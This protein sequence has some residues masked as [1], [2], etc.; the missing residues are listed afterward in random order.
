[1]DS[2]QIGD[3]VAE[4]G[5]HPVLETGAR[6]GYAV[7]GLLHMLI[8]VIA[9]R[10]AWQHSG[11]DADQSGALQAVG[12]NPLGMLLLWVIL[13][14]YVLL[15]LWQ[16]TESVRPSGG[17][18]GLV[19]RGKGLAKTA[20]YA[21]LALT[22][23]RFATGDSSSSSQQTA[24]FTATLMQA[25]FGRA[26]VAVVGLVVL[27]VGGYHVHKGVQKRFLRDLEEHPGR[28]AVHAGQFGYS[29]KGVA[30]A[31]VGVLF[32][33]AALRHQ[34]SQSTGLDGALRTLLGQPFGPYLL[35]VV[36]A[37]LA[38]YGGYSLARARHAKV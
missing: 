6:L 9:L 24:D 30:L 31:I 1:M 35:T 16:F 5:E 2:Q 37:G 25:P 29:A 13:I 11:Q 27:G 20:V 15:C 34:A 8:A 36:A 4:V 32:L 14:G 7:N 33:V 22:A 23:F 10:M 38:A 3:S 28:L 26:L 12:G 17:E 19:G 21:T 18:S